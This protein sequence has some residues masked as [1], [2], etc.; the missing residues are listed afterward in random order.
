[1]RNEADTLEAVRWLADRDGEDPAKAGL[2]DA[3]IGRPPSA[4]ERDVLPQL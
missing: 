3:R 2:R 4:T 1:M